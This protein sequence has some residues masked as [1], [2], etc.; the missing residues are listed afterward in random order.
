MKKLILLFGILLSV[1]TYSQET[2]ESSNEEKAIFPL[3][4]QEFRNMISRNFR[5]DKI[6]SI[7]N[8]NI[9]CELTFIIDKEGNI[10]DAKAYGCNKEFNE[11][12]VFAIS[13]IKEKWIPG[14]ING[15]PV[16][17]RYKVPLDIKFE[18]E[19]TQPT[20][21]RGNEEFINTLKENI[22][23]PKIAGKGMMN[24]EISF[25]VVKNGKLVDVKASGDNKSFNKEVV[26]A[27]S[28]IKG[29]WIPATINKIAVNKSFK[30]PFTINVE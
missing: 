29:K 18:N 23:L 15:V 7:G 30:L 19:D 13:Q 26:R 28:R 6:E 27:V 22:Y 11:E 3:G 9:H 12:A 4:N 14:K 21:F 5:T 16:R 20:Y 17:S 2:K 25:V 1:F 10:T 24:C 8:Q